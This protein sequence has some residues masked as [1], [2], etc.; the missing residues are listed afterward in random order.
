[1]LEIGIFCLKKKNRKKTFF[2]S[3]EKPGNPGQQ[4]CNIVFVKSTEL[5]R[6]SLVAV[7]AAPLA[8]APDRYSV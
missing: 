8:G 2:V 7:H 3:P 5:F 4:E 6:S 1:L